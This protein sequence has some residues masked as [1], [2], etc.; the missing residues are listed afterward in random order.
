MAIAYVQST[1][2]DAGTTT[3]STLAFGSNNVAGNTIIVGIRIGTVSQTI[4]VSDTR[5]NT[6]AS[7]LQ[8]DD[9]NGGNTVA[10][11]YALNIGA[12]ANTIT[13]SYTS[14][15][16]TLRWA[17]LEYSGTATSSPLDGTATNQQT[18]GDSVFSANI[19]T[20]VNG[21]LLIGIMVN[22]NGDTWTAGSGYTSR[23]QVPV[24][25]TSKL[26]LEDQIQSAAATVN[27][28]ATMAGGG[29]PWSAGIVAFKASTTTAIAVEDDTFNASLNTV[30]IQQAE[31]N[32]SV[33]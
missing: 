1:S 24:G 12:G 31:P 14:G 30:F 27:A 9:T 16:A 21:D 33:W 10:V 5:G 28:T 8:F 3:S 17:Q 15:S 25:G 23:E 29:A 2:K 22:A 11:F 4:T 7:A 18:T 13:V 20:T 32:V 19:T 6:Y 26:M